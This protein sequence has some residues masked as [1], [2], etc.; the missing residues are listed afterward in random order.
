MHKL[1]RTSYSRYVAACRPSSYRAVST[2]R[3]ASL[4]IACSLFL[5]LLFYIPHCFLANIVC[6]PEGSGWTLKS[7]EI[8]EHTVWLI[9]ALIV[10]LCHRLLPSLFIVIFNIKVIA[11]VRKVNRQF[12][13]KKKRSFE[14]DDYSRGGDRSSSIAISEKIRLNGS[15]KSLDDN[16]KNKEQQSMI[17][18]DV[19]SKDADTQIDEDQHKSDNVTDISEK[20]PEKAAAITE[21]TESGKVTIHISQKS[22]SSSKAGETHS[23]GK[24]KIVKD[25]I[26]NVK[27]KN[28]REQME[29][30]LSNLLLS[31][32][33]VFLVTTL[34]AALLAL[35][36]TSSAEFR[37]FG[38]EVGT[39]S[40]AVKEN[41]LDLFKNCH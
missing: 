38:Y 23:K 24:R 30:Q 13:E 34:P 12:T 2:P 28:S 18:N 7:N 22:N 19:L 41:R 40:N 4:R 8:E 26:K 25:S 36:D 20:S 14:K 3:V 27:T 32:I 29:K 9:W 6:N 15:R 11:K 33:V 31:I 39:W 1:N 10:E 16:I 5:P 21:V 17:C 37:S 35:T